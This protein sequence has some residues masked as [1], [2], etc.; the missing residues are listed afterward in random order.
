LFPA[1]GTLGFIKFQGNNTLYN[2][3]DPGNFM[4]GKAFGL[5]GYSLDE[6]RAG[7][8][9][10]QPFSETSADQRS[11]KAGYNHTG[12]NWEK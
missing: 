4:T 8:R 2:V 9:L 7:A 3:S 5:V 11:I 6:L 10:N 1:D 12:V